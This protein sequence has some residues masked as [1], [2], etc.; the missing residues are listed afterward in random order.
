MTAPN[1]PAAL[2][3]AESEQSGET[4]TQQLVAS[5]IAEH[6]DAVAEH[7]ERFLVLLRAATPNIHPFDR[8]AIEAAA[9]DYAT[10][11]T[12]RA[13]DK[14]SNQMLAAHRRRP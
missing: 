4:F 7:W 6:P 10:A 5:A 12:C 14:L 8:Y 11:R 13:L 1:W 2:A 9:T 3:A